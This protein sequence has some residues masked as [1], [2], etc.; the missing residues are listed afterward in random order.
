M[1]MMESRPGTLRRS[2]EGLD[3]EPLIEEIRIFLLR[4]FVFMTVYQIA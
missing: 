2:S 3:F 1:P 4:R